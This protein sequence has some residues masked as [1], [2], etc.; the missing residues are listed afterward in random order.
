M[1]ATLRERAISE[2]RCPDPLGPVIEA[3][4]V[5]GRPRQIQSFKVYQL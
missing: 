5:A 3:Q 1:K 4:G 2:H